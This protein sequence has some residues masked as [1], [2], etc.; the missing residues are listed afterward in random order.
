MVVWHACWMSSRHM[1]GYVFSLNHMCPLL[2]NRCGTSLHGK[3]ATLSSIIWHCLS[4]ES[5][6]SSHI[7]TDASLD[8][9]RSVSYSSACLDDEYIWT[10]LMWS[11]NLFASM[12]VYGHGAS[13]SVDIHISHMVMGQLHVWICTCY[14]FEVNLFYWG[15]WGSVT[16]AY[17]SVS[18]MDKGLL[19]T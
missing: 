10:V 7:S 3:L 8:E 11:H 15:L 9:H 5:W 6:L 18:L 14:I 12:N 1:N 19:C 13:L 17:G 2:R 4:Y 16:R